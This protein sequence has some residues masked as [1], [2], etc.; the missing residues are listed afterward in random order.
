VG[1]LNAYK[2]SRVFFSLEV[3]SVLSSRSETPS[4]GM[5]LEAEEVFDI[6]SDENITSEEQDFLI[7]VFFLKREIQE[8][9]DSYSIPNKELE[10]LMK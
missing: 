3:V 9:P 10:T 6:L 8:F 1:L 7:E 5:D 4:L 2:Y